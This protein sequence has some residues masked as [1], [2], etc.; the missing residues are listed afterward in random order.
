MIIV[1]LWIRN[2]TDQFYIKIIQSNKS[3]EGLV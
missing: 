3:N 2:L 1:L